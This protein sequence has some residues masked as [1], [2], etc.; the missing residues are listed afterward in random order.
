MTR[1]CTVCLHPLRL[2]IDQELLKGQ[3]LR[4]VGRKYTLTKDALRRH[5]N[6][7]VSA[8]LAKSYEANVVLS[9]DGIMRQMSDLTAT[10]RDTYDDARQG[11]EVREIVRAANSLREGLEMLAKFQ[12]LLMDRVRVAEEHNHE[13][14]KIVFVSA[15]D[16]SDDELAGVIRDAG[17]D[18]DQVKPSYG[19]D[20]MSEMK[21]IATKENQIIEQLPFEDPES[22]K[23]DTTGIN[24]V[25]SL[26]REVKEQAP[27]P[28]TSH[29]VSIREIMNSNSRSRI[30]RLL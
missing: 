14:R 21:D 6:S 1:T 17:E 24:R 27:K 23:Y 3:S 4:D 30:P 26:D 12:L 28:D 15:K 5:K 8:A 20:S 25:E 2:E 13:P 16:L 18:S 7:H 19:R 9:V 22:P 11:G 10:M 29:I